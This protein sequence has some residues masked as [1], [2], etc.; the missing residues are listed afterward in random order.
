MKLLCKCKTPKKSLYSGKCEECGQ[1]YTQCRFCDKPTKNSGT[2]MCD[3]C[4]EV[5]HRIGAMGGEVLHKIVERSL[6]GWELIES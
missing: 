3:Q 6:I 2:V 4:W 1:F 5:E